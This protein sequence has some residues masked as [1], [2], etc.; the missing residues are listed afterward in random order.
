MDPWRHAIRSLRCASARVAAR[1][2]GCYIFETQATL[3]QQYDDVIQ[4][5]C[6]F[7]DDLLLIAVGGGQGKFDAFLTNF[8]RDAA[9]AGCN[10]TCRVA[11]AGRALQALPYDGFEF[12]YKANI[13][14]GHYRS[15]APH[16][17][18]IIGEVLLES[19]YRDL[20]A[21]KH[22]RGKRAVDTRGIEDLQEMFAGT[23]SARRNERHI[24]LFAH[25]G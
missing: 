22:T 15:L 12:G 3:G 5:I 25:R 11:F 14:L 13:R 23:R 9:G 19:R 24:A 10:E 7:I 1:Q 4:E 6:G 20:A 21:V 17:D 16:G 8:L 18:A 2:A